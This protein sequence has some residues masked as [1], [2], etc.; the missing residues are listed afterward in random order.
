[1]SCIDKPET[2][3]CL[4]CSETIKSTSPLPLQ[5]G[6]FNYCDHFIHS[7]KNTN[8]SVISNKKQENGKHSVAAITNDITSI[9][10]RLRSFFGLSHLYTFSWQRRKRRTF[11]TKLKQDC[12]NILVRFLYTLPFLVL[13][14][15]LITPTNA[16]QPSP[17]SSKSVSS[18]AVS[19]NPSYVSKA[20][21]LVISSGDYDAKATHP[22]EANINFDTPSQFEGRS[23]RSRKQRGN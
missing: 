10:H 23:S 2:S 16:I 19:Y 12:F 7:V 3:A 15:P 1:M 6:K 4:I 22:K 9:K 5:D 21:H 13:S 20:R 11:H 8:N 14:C 18:Y 17:P